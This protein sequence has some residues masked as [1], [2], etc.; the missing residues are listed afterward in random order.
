MFMSTCF[1]TLTYILLI[2]LVDDFIIGLVT[3]V[4]IGLEQDAVNRI[5]F[6]RRQFCGPE[7]GR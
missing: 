4:A 3:V 5:R 6:S 7:K 1:D 2:R